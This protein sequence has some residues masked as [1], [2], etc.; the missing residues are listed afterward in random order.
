[1]SLAA[2][3]AGTALSWTSPVNGQLNENT[4]LPVT[5]DQ[6]KK[7]CILCYLTLEIQFCW[8]IKRKNKRQRTSDIMEWY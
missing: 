6:S 3:A 8:I 1:M 5:D 7:S 4:T 2:V